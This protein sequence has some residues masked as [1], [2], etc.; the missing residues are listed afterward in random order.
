MLPIPEFFFI[1]EIVILYPGKSPKFLKIPE[2][3]EKWKHWYNIIWKRSIQ[4][5]HPAHTCF[6]ALH[7]RVGLHQVGACHESPHLPLHLSIQGSRGEKIRDHHGNHLVLQ[8]GSLGEES[9]ADDD[10]QCSHHHL[11]PVVLECVNGHLGVKYGWIISVICKNCW[12]TST[13]S[14]L[15]V[16][17]QFI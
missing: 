6:H 4:S 10:L 7:D 1:L 9:S 17:L 14:Q 8:M 13:F 2:F 16:N 12:P 15:P 3:R 11:V 5:P